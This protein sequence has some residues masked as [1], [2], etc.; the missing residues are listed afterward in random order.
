MRPPGNYIREVMAEHC[1]TQ[2]MLA[3]LLGISLKHMNEICQGKVN[4][5]ARLALNLEEVTG[6]E[7]IHWM[8]RDANYRI[9]KAKMEKEGDQV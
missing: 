8:I 6:I 9:Q 7:A 4:L 2:T 1:W 3:D 5:T